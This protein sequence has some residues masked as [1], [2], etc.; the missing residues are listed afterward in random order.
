MNRL[1]LTKEFRLLSSLRHPH[2]IKVLD[3]GFDDNLTPY[4]TMELLENPQTILEAGEGLNFG[5]KWRL[6]MQ[7]L[8]ALQYL[9]RRGVL[10][11]D[12]KPDNVLVVEGQV[13]VLDF[14]LAGAREYRRAA[15]VSCRCEDAKSQS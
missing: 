8:Q 4:Y 3:Y 2:I 12:L 7:L 14:G 15:A 6:I 13:K 10:H 5:G 11:R 1:A 9:H